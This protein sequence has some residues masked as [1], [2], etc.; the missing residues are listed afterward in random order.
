M[1][2][3]KQFSIFPNSFEIIKNEFYS[4]EPLLMFNDKLN[5]EYLSEDLLQIHSESKNITIDLRW[6]GD[7]SNNKGFFKIYV[8]KN[9][10]WENPLKI[11][12]SKSQ[13]EISEKLITIIESIV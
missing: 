1:K 6:Y 5:Y 4:Y 13:K 8:V 11:E 3:K 9:Q 2:F 12:K 7:L 10:D